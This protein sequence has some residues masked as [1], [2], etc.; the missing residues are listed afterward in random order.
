MRYK[1]LMRIFIMVYTV[2]TLVIVHTILTIKIITII[3]LVFTVD[4]V[5][6]HIPTV[7]IKNTDTPIYQKKNLCIPNT[8]DLK[9]NI[10][11]R[12]F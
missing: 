7:F 4:T 11:H 1:C 10:T 2:E 9:L 8:G 3:H 5:I 12:Q 6:I